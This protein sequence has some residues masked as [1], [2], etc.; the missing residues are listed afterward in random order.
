MGDSPYEETSRD[1]LVQTMAA[2]GSLASGVASELILPLRELRD[3]LAIMV[4][5]LDKHIAGAGGPVP[6]PWN[7]TKAMRERLAEAYLSARS[8]TRLTGD[9]AS[10]VDT[11]GS[12]VEAVDLNKLVEGAVNLTRHRM[13]ADTEVFIDFGRLPTVKAIPGELVLAVARLLM[14][15]SDSA[16]RVDSGAISIKTRREQDPEAGADDVVIYIADNGAG[17][18][19]EAAGASPLLEQLA[20]H[21][22]GRFVGASEPGSGS[23]FEL[24]WPVE[25]KR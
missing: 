5:K 20:E 25:R 18:P 13:S 2:A 14:I 17:R 24:R 10:A 11:R 8:I 21:L 19:E 23:V 3:S 4:E 7:Q 15:A 16:R 9:L 6:L 12:V 22:G 1:V